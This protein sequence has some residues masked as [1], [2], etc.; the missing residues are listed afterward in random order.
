[1]TASDAGTEASRRWRDHGRANGLFLAPETVSGYLAAAERYVKRHPGYHVGMYPPPMTPDE[2]G[3]PDEQKRKAIAAEHEGLSIIN[4]WTANRSMTNFETFDIEADAMKEPAAITARKLLHRA[5]QYARL[6]L[7]DKA[8]EA[9]REGF[10]NWKQVLVLKNDCRIRRA[11][12]RDVSLPGAGCR[13]FRDLDK[14]QE[15][16][17]EL[18][19]K[20]VDI[21]HTRQKTDLERATPW[22][23]DILAH[24]GDALAPL[25]V[26]G[27]MS[28]LGA[29]VELPR[30]K[31]APIEV[32]ARLAT[33][34]DLPA[35]RLAGPL[36][37]TMDDG[38]PWI[39]EDVKERVRVKL[40]LVKQPANVIPPKTG[41]D[42]APPD[43]PGN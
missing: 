15:D 27:D 10:A 1:M 5:D 32:E 38:T 22:V 25:R 33:V 23:L 42:R 21:L 31:D 26:V 3:E 43:V 6:A 20:Y 24:T 14:Y 4:A 40:G 28:V 39:P 30:K 11:E 8:D 13:D 7:F 12:N 41:G 29:E 35:L 18:N 19:L 16:M 2:V 9:Y 17:Y 34:R 37:G 36:D